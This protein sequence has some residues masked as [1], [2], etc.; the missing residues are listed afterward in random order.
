MRPA[1]SPKCPVCRA[2]FRGERSCP[3]CGAE[4]G[5]LMELAARA[6]EARSAARAALRR[7]DVPRADLLARRAQRLHD[8]PEGRSLARFA[9][10]MRRVL[11]S[12]SD[13]RRGRG[14]ITRPGR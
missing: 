3:R 1:S 2:P 4:L 7:G 11:N 5:A 8:T 14:R 9:G 6:H 12:L 10:V 13:L